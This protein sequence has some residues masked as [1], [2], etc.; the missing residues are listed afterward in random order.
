[1]QYPVEHVTVPSA[2]SGCSLAAQ[3]QWEEICMMEESFKEFGQA[4]EAADE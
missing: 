3:R 2:C 1:M 4:E